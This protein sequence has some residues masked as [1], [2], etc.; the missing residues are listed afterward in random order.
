MG[1]QK[2]PFIARES[3]THKRAK[4]EASKYCKNAFLPS[5]DV[6]FEYPIC[7]NSTGAV[8]G[9]YPAW[10]SAIP[11]YEECKG[12]GLTPILVLDI[13]VVGTG[14]LIA[15]VEVIHTNAP[16]T[17]KLA[18]LHQMLTQTPLF[19]MGFVFAKAFLALPESQRKI[20]FHPFVR[21]ATFL[22]EDFE[23]DWTKLSK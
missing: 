5:V 16:D 6:Y 13:G 15:G 21:G 23:P 11:S 18:A 9:I 22:I 1:S 19:F 3:R 4:I 7:V 8:V 17:R 2:Q 10:D 12:N 20:R 14:Q